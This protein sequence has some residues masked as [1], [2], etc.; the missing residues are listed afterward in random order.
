MALGNTNITVTL[1]KNTIGETTNRISELVL[2]E[3]VNRWGINFPSMSGLDVAKWWGKPNPAAPYPLGIFR[4]YDHTWRCFSFG[5]KNVP[6]YNDWQQHYIT[7]PIRFFP[8]WSVEPAVTHYFSIWYKTTSDFE[9]GGYQVV[10]DNDYTV[11]NDGTITINFNPLS[12]PF[13]G[14]ESPG[15]RHYYYYIIHYSSPARRWDDN[16]SLEV[17]TQKGSN[18]GILVDVYVPAYPWNE[19]VWIGNRNLTPGG[20]IAGSN[21]YVGTGGLQ[22]FH[23]GRLGCSGNIII[24]YCSSNLFPPEQTLSLSVPF[25]AAGSIPPANSEGHWD[26]PIGC[27]VYATV[28]HYFNPFNSVYLRTK[29]DSVVG[30][31]N[32]SS[33]FVT[34]TE[35]GTILDEPPGP[36]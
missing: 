24:E 15:N 13:G 34:S 16:A 14:G 4:G 28:D 30:A 7:I 32:S 35:V 9:H 23:N 18:W 33:S 27:S 21:G 20:Y 10:N 5:E 36:E 26:D 8:A 12:L 11:N 1:V 6:S 3:K 22:I 29:L 25:T 31:T 17:L 19:T 2:S